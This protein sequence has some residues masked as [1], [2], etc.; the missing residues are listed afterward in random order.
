[1][2][3][4]RRFSGSAD[5][6]LACPATVIT[7][8]RALFGVTLGGGYRGEGAPAGGQVVAEPGWRVGD[9]GQQQK[10]QGS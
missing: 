9:L 2:P 3:Q 10:G 1:M 7:F 5:A 4:S 6:A 8:R